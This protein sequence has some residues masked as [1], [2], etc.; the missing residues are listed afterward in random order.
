MQ[1]IHSLILFTV[2]FAFQQNAL[3]QKQE[4]NPEPEERT[5]EM[6]KAFIHKGMW[7]VGGNFSYRTNT[8]E[9]FDVLGGI[10]GDTNSDKYRFKVSP[11]F[12]YFL[13]DDFAIGGRF[14][15]QRDKLLGSSDLLSDTPYEYDELSQEVSAKLFIRNYLRLGKSNRFALFNETRLGY[16]Y[17]E[18]KSI[19]TV[20]GE[21]NGIFSRTHKLS[22]GVTPG[23]VAF[24]NDVVALEVSLD[25][26]GFSTEWENR[27]ENR[28]EESKRTVSNADF[29]LDLLSLNLGIA[30]YF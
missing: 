8:K 28:V 25:V 10:L 2:L 24:I 11:F 3:A 18:G 20:D 27:V 30:F 21:T 17:G 29:K 22:I 12:A 23:L 14:A 19:T 16:T 26:L 5:V 13:K 9:D 4:S 15:Y 6:P 7:L 1:Y